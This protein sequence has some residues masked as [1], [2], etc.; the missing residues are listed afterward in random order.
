LLKLF[1]RRFRFERAP[2]F[3][4]GKCGRCVITGIAT[5]LCFSVF[6]T[7]IHLTGLPA[8]LDPPVKMPTPIEQVVAF[9]K[10]GG[11]TTSFSGSG[12]ASP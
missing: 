5:C 7:S 9:H 8:D 1:S 12:Y 3:C 2:M 11:V 10:L 6:V 4:C